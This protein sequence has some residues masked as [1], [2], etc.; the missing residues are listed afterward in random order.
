M[1]AGSGVMAYVVHAGSSSPLNSS[2][3]LNNSLADGDLSGPNLE[4]YTLYHV[5]M[6]IAS[7]YL[8]LVLAFGLPGNVASIFTILSMPTVSS[9]K[10]HVAILA[11]ADMLAIILKI[12]YLL[13]SEHSIHVTGPGC[14]VIMFSQQFF[15]CYVNWVVVAMTAERCLAVCFP[16][17]VGRMY[18]RRKA[19]LVLACF[20]LMTSA[21]YFFFFWA[22]EEKHEEGYGFWCQMKEEYQ[23]FVRN[24]FYWLDGFYSALLPCGF[25]LIGNILIIINIKR[26]RKAQRHLTNTFD[27]STRKGRDQRQITIMLV[28]V[29]IV[30]LVLNIP[31]AVL[32]FLKPYWV[33]EENSY[34][35]VKFRFTSHL[36]HVLSDSNHAVNFYL[37]FLSMSSFR[38]RFLDAIRCRGRRRQASSSLYRTS[39]TYVHSAP[40]GEGAYKLNK[41]HSCHSLKSCS[42]SNNNKLI[43]STSGDATHASLMSSSQL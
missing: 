33:Y 28:L 10:A 36:V 26:A 13:I 41:T 15:T 25:I 8:W 32:Y 23:P 12:T 21:E 1:D 7:Y 3:N 6:F 35:Q 20:L 42:N 38:R 4:D 34:E 14:A 19:L 11:V 16:L 43:H 24:I 30:F 29:S 37:Y 17:R 39:Q 5:D 22:W 40:H 18:T 31:N 9:S 27:Q 2:L